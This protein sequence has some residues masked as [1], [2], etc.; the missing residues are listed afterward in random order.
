MINGNVKIGF[1]IE[2]DGLKSYPALENVSINASNYETG[3][4]KWVHAAI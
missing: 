2:C 1:T 3:E 4:L